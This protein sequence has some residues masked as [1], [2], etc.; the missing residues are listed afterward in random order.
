M[1]LFVLFLI[2]LDTVLLVLLLPRLLFRPKPVDRIRQYFGD[3]EELK[4]DSEINNTR[5]DMKNIFSAASSVMFQVFAFKGLRER[6]E[7]SL[8]KADIA[9]TAEE[10]LLIIFITAI[11][12]ATLVYV[13]SGIIILSLFVIIL[14]CLLYYAM[15]DSRIKKRRQ[16]MNEQL[17]DALDM[18][19]GSLRTGFSFMKAMEV[20]AN[21]M[22][23]PISREFKRVIKEVDVGL[24][25]DQALH[26]L[27]ERM[28][29]DDLELMVTAI[30]IQ[31]QVG[32]NLAEI[33]DN[34]SETIRS[35]ISLKREIRVLAAPGKVSGIIVALLPP[36]F[37]LILFIMDPK[38]IG[39]L[40]TN[41]IGIIMLMVAA[42]N[43]CIGFLI[44]RKMVDVE[45]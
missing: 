26:N 25:M 7:R 34:I 29:S 30:V 8:I 39:A 27:L 20:T 45:Y 16:K 41:K 17:A 23:E 12:A 11:M 19:S 38:Y 15:I 32:G 37:G 44:I 3:V 31:R 14:V 22:G 42:F 1:R 6:V 43:E 28:S 35:R 4:Q 33:L 10:M 5:K 40:F 36:L 21:D 2:F 9:F 13:I 18:I 24:T